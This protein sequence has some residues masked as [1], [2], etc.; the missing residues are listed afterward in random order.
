[1]LMAICLFVVVNFKNSFYLAV[2]IFVNYVYPLQY[3][4][5]VN[6]LVKVHELIA[7]SG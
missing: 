2:V 6:R 5:S 1:M 3:L 7:V 4:Q